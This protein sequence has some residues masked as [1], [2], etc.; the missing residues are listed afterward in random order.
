MGLDILLAS[1]ESPAAQT[2]AM[3]ADFVPEAMALG[4]AF[5]YGGASGPLLAMLMALQNLPEGFNAYRERAA[6]SREFNATRL[7]GSFA[8]MA[9]L[10]PV[11]GLIGYYGLSPYPS[12][13]AAVMLFAAGGILY[14]VFQDI[15]P[16]AKLERHWAPP[17]GALAGF[18]LGVVGHQLSGG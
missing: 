8:L 9:L 2:M 7:V 4:A 15:A 18:A 11:A 10:G 14:A 12:V 16:Q 13:V 3:L 6:A 17:L 5:A 1:R